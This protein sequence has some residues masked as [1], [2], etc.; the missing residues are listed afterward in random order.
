MK[1]GTFEQT[2]SHDRR[3]FGRIYI[4]LALVLVLL[5]GGVI[6][7][8][9]AWLTAQ[10]DSVNNVF[11]PSNISVEL[12][13]TPREYKMVP[14]HTIA[15]NP[16]VIV[17]TGS[18]PCWLF[19]EVAE[20]H[21]LNEYIEYEVLQ[22]ANTWTRGKGDYDAETNPEGDNIP[23][24][25]YYREVG[26]DDMGEWFPILVNDQVTVKEAVTEEMMDAIT[27]P[28]PQPTLT[29]TAYAVQLFSTNGDRFEVDEAWDIAK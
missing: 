19:V 8:T 16:K 14:G 3:T 25:V 2:G 20:L 15:K 10:S 5:V 11:T 1:K 4:A 22:T 18:E 6:G 12:T 27:T 9:L 17:N 13:E 29:F 26:T 28:N 23:P 7:G 24:N 21:K